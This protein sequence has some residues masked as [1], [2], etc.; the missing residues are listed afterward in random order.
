MRA[1]QARYSTRNIL[2]KFVLCVAFSWH[3]S[4][5]SLPTVGPITSRL[6]I[7]QDPTNVLPEARVVGNRLAVPS[8]LHHLERTLGNRVYCDSVGL[9]VSW[10]STHLVTISCFVI[11]CIRPI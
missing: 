9:G 10:S 3:S 8:R 2:V 1:N 11:P 5:T 4:N 7:Q 6:Q